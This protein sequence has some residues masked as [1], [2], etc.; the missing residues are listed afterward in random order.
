MPHL[1]IRQIMDELN[2]LGMT[3]GHMVLIT[4]LVATCLLAG[5]KP[6]TERNEN[7]T[8]RNENVT[9]LTGAERAKRF[10]IKKKEGFTESNESNVTTLQT[11]IY[12][13]INNSLSGKGGVGGKPRKSLALHGTRLPDDWGPSENLWTWGKEKLHEPELRFE[14]AGFKD[15]WAAKPGAAGTKLD[16][17]KT[18]KTWIREAVRRRS[19]FKPRDNVTEFRS[20]GPKRTWAEIKSEREGSAR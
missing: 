14:T 15:F 6:V 8:N 9:P 19:R 3:P 12:N 13:N 10:R 2:D 7:V 16:W 4:E 17:D 18:W 5:P 1:R 11:P 20:S